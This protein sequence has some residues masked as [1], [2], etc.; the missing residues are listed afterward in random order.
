[1]LFSKL[2]NAERDSDGVDGVQALELL[3]RKRTMPSAHLFAEDELMDG[4]SYPSSSPPP[5]RCVWRAARRAHCVR[6]AARARAQGLRQRAHVR[7]HQTAPAAG[8][9]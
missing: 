3:R 1:M 9:R 7:A 4:I 2:S 6:G 8:P 5:P